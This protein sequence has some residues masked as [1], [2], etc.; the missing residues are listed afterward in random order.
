MNR[1]DIPALC[2]LLAALACSGPIHART[3][4]KPDVDGSDTPAIVVLHTQSCEGPATLGWD[5]HPREAEFRARGSMPFG[6]TGY[7]ID[8][9]RLGP[10]RKQTLVERAHDLARGVDDSYALFSPSGLA[11]YRAAYVVTRM[12]KGHD[13]S[14]DAM[15]ATAIAFQRR[16]AGEGKI[17]FVAVRTPL[18]EGVEMLAADRVGSACFPTAPFAY[19]QD[20]AA[21]SLGI[22]RF[23]VRGSDLV[24]YAAIVPWPDGVGQEE[25]IARAREA[26]AP[27]EAALAP[28]PQR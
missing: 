18:G 20:A 3:P 24:E 10:L 15:M 26:L 14:P 4:A 19:A 5:R 8:L 22:S 11:P 21:S 2:L 12:P 23:V 28:E 7:R 9:T 27:L 25:A 16:N 17:S 6:D 1:P 13:M